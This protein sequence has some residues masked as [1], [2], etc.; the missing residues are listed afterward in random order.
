MPSVAPSVYKVYPSS[1]F[2]YSNTRPT[3]CATFNPPH[4]LLQVRTENLKQAKQR[5][6][7]YNGA[8]FAQANRSSNASSMT[9]L[10]S[11]ADAGGA[12]DEGASGGGE[13]TLDM[14]QDMVMYSQRVRLH[15]TRG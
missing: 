7:V 11:A 9:N 15:I 1:S 4:T 10:L 12:A 2:F 8:S 3:L 6:D 13:V 5:R 14:G